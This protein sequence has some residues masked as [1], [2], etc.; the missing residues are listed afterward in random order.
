[1]SLFKS[2]VTLVTKVLTIGE[3]YQTMTLSA[4]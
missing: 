1:V 3:G 2:F 4:Q